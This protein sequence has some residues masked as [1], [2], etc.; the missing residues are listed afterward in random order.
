M[1]L[2]QL[3]HCYGLGALASLLALGVVFLFAQIGVGYTDHSLYAISLN[4]LY[5]TAFW[6]GV[7]GAF[8]TLPIQWRYEAL[9]ALTAGGLGY[10]YV[11]YYGYQSWWPQAWLQQGLHTPELLCWGIISGVWWFV[12]RRL[13]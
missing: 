9:L 11:G 1:T 6:G 2:A 12:W 4:K 5:F 10:L 7:A 13:G 3:A 8:L